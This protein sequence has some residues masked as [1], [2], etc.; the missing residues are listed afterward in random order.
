MIEPKYIP[1]HD[2]IGFEVLSRHKLSQEKDEYVDIGLV[3][4]ET[5][6]ML[7]T[8]KNHHVKKYIK[9]D[10]VFRIK[11]SEGMLEVNGL[12]IIGVP[13]NRLRSL[14]KKKRLRR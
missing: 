6:N 7:I 12:K 9:K 10:H 13:E 11:L 3:I 5:K 4:D 1:Y 14:K 8:E 2:L